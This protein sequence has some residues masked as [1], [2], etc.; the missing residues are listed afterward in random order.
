MGARARLAPHYILNYQNDVEV[1]QRG[2]F[3][4]ATGVL[5][6]LNPPWPC[7]DQQSLS[8]DE[9]LDE[10]G[11]AGR[12]N[13]TAAGVSGSRSAGLELSQGLSS[14][15]KDK[16]LWDQALNQQLPTW[17]SLGECLK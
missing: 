2:Y 17:Y 7:K 4:V 6:G 5:Q 3:T 12:F 10:A 15:W 1:E 13:P 8:V 14:N 16:S 9:G 11:P